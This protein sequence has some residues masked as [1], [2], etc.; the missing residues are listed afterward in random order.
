MTMGKELEVFV[1]PQTN[2]KKKAA[3]QIKCNDH[4]QIRNLLPTNQS[5]NT[6]HNSS[7]ECQSKNQLLMVLK[8]KQY[9]QLIRLEDLFDKMES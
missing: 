5:I 2:P 3:Q 1:S 7:L 6:F 9:K 8:Q 4:K